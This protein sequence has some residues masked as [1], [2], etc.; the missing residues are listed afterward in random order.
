MVCP[1]F[2]FVAHT[3]GIFLPSCAVTPH[4]GALFPSFVPMR[5]MTPLILIGTPCY[6]GMVLQGYMESIIQLMTYAASNGFQV[7][8]ALLGGDSLITRSRNKLVATFLE[9]KQA[10]HLMFIDADI[11]FRAEDVHRMLSFDH[12]LVAGMYPVKNFDWAQ[13]KQRLTPETSVEQ[14]AE[15]GLH[16]VG[17]PTPEKD[18]EYRNGCVSGVYAGTGFMLMRRSCLERMILAYP[19]TKYDVAHVYPIPKERSDSLYALFDCMIEPGTNIYLS[20]D[21]A[22]CHRWRAIGGKVWLDPLCRLTH[23]GAFRFQGTPPVFDP[24]PPV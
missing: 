15:S 12:D 23:H 6:G 24:T 4:S 13:A 16:F 9:M 19:E 7:S 5:P 3:C 18:R 10:T 21:F 11:S 17:L 22:F 20:E 2:F 1:A 8:L 14:M